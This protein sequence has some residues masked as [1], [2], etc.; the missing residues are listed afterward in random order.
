MF[1][2]K[3]NLLSAFVLLNELIDTMNLRD[4]YEELLKRESFTSDERMEYLLN[5]R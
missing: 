5:K 3:S 4:V 2:H 1:V